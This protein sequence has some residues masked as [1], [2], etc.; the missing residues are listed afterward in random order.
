MSSE[1]QK[2]ICVTLANAAELIDMNPEIIR[3]T[4]VATGEITSM[5]SSGNTRGSRIRVMYDELEAYAAGG[6]DG[7]REFRIKHRRVKRKQRS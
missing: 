1:T 5:R 7:L 2:P 3:R 6:I 4:L